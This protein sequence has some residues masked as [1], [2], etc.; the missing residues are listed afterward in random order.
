MKELIDKLASVTAEASAELFCAAFEQAQRNEAE[1]ARLRTEAWASLDDD[2][3]GECLG[4][5]EW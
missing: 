3:S 4:R 1:R 5:A 2:E